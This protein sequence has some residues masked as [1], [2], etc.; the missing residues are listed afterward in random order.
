MNRIAPVA[1]LILAAVF[2]STTGF[3]CGSAET[4]SAKLYMQQKQWDKAEAS[5]TKEVTKND[6]NEEAWYLLGAV[7]LEQKRYNEMN[8]AYAK[9][10][11]LSDAHKK[12]ITTN[13]LAVWGMLYND[14]VKYFNAGR[15]DSSNY[16]KALDAFKTAVA[17]EPDSASTYYVL[18][19]GC[20]SQKDYDGTVNA[21]QIAL[22]KK[23]RFADAASF[24]GRAHYARAV[25]QINA[26]DTAGAKKTF[27]KSV[28]AFEKA[29]AI[30]PD[31]VVNI[32]NLIDVYERTGNTEKATSLTKDAVTREP[33]NKFFRYAYG[34]FLLKQDRFADCIEQFQK[35][36]EIDPN[37]ADSRYN[38]GVAYLNWGVSMK[39]AS[40]EKAD[41]DQL[42]AGRGKQVKNDESYREKFK[43]AL[44]PLERSAELRT[45]DAALF[46]QLGR[47][48]AILNMS[49]KS[50]AAFEKADKI[51]KGQ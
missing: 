10:L 42:K 21:L 3:Q 45:D 11:A 6:K 9:A 36:I 32:T 24:L 46:Q 17:L 28:D 38:L 4:T 31:S 33:N 7:R 1:V 14:G 48:Y 44:P 39:K 30:E 15:D 34:V 49:D 23:P 22:A 26:K 20:S 25:E 13:K 41:A 35:A 18:A 50:K 12:E 47:L 16:V 43:L 37:Y 19:L 29:Y 2:F 27:L 5:L 8:D 51:T 40:D